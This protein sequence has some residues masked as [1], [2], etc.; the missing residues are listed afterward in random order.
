MSCVHET[1]MKS[2]GGPSTKA[3]AVED[4]DGAGKPACNPQ[5]IGSVGKPTTKALGSTKNR[6]LVCSQL[7][8][9]VAIRNPIPFQ[10]ESRTTG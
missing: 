9:D 5:N 1:I 10:H 7:V 6:S 2:S 8:C 4:V 3:P